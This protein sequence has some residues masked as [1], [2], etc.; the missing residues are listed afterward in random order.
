MF[1]WEKAAR[2]SMQTPFGVI[3]P[4]GLLDPAEDLAARANFEATGPAA[5]NSFEFGMS[6]FGV[7]NMAGNVTE[8]LANS[9]DSG[10]TTVGG[11]WKDP[12][13]QFG[14]YEARPALH[15]S[16]TLGFRC[17]LVA[18]SAGN[19]GDIHFSSAAR[20]VEYP[21]SSE[22]EFQVSRMRYGYERSPLHAKIIATTDTE[23]WKREEIA[24]DG[25]GG[26]RA[27]GFLYLPKNAS[28]PYQVIQ[29]VGG[30]SWFYGVPVTQVVERNN[31]RIAPYI[32]AGRAVFLVVL[33]G[34]AG[35][36]PVGAYGDLELGSRQHRDILVS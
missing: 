7:Y 19:Q 30:G 20:S 24:F 15:T 18:K 8:W 36:E 31:S 3:E 23:S 5:V 32:R 6:P 12:I 4:W 21:V 13:Y 28:P 2:G 11:S 33:K 17:A 27:T 1:E 34:F 35:R 9:Y 29:F 14:A 25:Y 22:R 26:E 16:E 10:F